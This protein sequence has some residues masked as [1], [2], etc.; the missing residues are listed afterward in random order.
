MRR[1]L[2]VAVALLGVATACSN[3]SESSDAPP[4]GAP[5]ETVRVTDDAG[6][7]GISVGLY[8]L[9]QGYG[10]REFEVQVAN[11]TDKLMRVERATY[12]SNRF[13]KPAVWREGTRIPGGFTID[14]SLRLAPARCSS[15]SPQDK[16]ILEFRQ[17][18][19]GLLRRTYK[20]EMMYN[21]LPRFVDAECA[22][23]QVQ[24]IADV[25]VA[26]DIEIHGEGRE[27]VAELPLIIEP[28]GK[29]GSFTLDSI[30]A[31]TL[32]S[33]STGG[34][35]WDLDAKVDGTGDPQREVLRIGPTRCD[36]HALSDNSQGTEFTA[37]FT[38]DGGQTTQFALGTSPHLEGR[39]T[40]F[41]AAHCGYGPDVEN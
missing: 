41:V 23:N 34:D 18:G 3:S 16:V 14:L 12:V 11:N 37:I 17:G 38:L 7:P 30:L 36:S 9:R 25:H 2:I 28:T 10:S 1:V 4:S 29:E 6:P 19:S 31:T 26:D 13:E 27:S 40:S 32:I 39:L 24:K 8:Q 15:E 35:S 5:E 20:P 33:P 22:G 21:A